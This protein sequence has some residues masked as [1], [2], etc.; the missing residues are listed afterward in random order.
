MLDIGMFAS[1]V[2]VSSMELE[3]PLGYW[4]QDIH[5]IGLPVTIIRQLFERPSYVSTPYGNPVYSFRKKRRSL[6]GFA[7]VVCTS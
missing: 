3:E 5:D 4:R 1:V 7:F 2:K 6:N